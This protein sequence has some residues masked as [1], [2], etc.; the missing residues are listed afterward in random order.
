MALVLI[1]GVNG[2][3]GSHIAEKLLAAGHTVRGLIRKTSDLKFIIDFDIE[4]YYGDITDIESVKRAMTG[5][6]VVVHNA[7]L[8]SD[9][10]HFSTFY[11]ANVAG[12]QNVAKS[13]AEAGVHR[14]VDIC[15]SAIYGFGDPEPLN[16]LSSYKKSIFHYVETKRLSALWLNEFEKTC[17]MEFTSICPGNVFG[18]RD[19]T[20]IEKYFDA[21][22]DGKGG[23]VSGGLTK[24][25]PVY[26]ENLADAIVLACF[27]PDAAGED[28]LITDGLDID[29]KTFTEL[30]CDELGFKKPKM[31]IPFPVGYAIAFV[32]EMIYLLFAVKTPPL[33]TRYRI[34]NGGSNYWFSID[35]AKRMLGWKPAVGLEEAI[36][37]SVAWYKN[38]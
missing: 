6:D 14:F 13:A 24:T 4:L 31:S 17:P 38:K 37:R 1:T 18:T 34:S 26:V 7:A 23:Y 21:L 10:G 19:H 15:T 11:N 25:C 29:W 36:R 16:E 22:R 5:V 9:W 32:W 3:I 28:F 8:A 35:K 33:L 27:H 2:F 20:F 12:V 30:L